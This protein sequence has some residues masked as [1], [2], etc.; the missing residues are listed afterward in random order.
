MS[1][2]VGAAARAAAYMRPADPAKRRLRADQL[3]MA[4]DNLKASTLSGIIVMICLSAASLLWMASPLVAVWLAFTIA[5]MAGA[6]WISARIGAVRDDADAVLRL[7]REFLGL[8]ALRSLA[9]AL[10]PIAMWVA[11]RPDNHV[12]LLVVLISGATINVVLIA[13]YKPAVAIV[14]VYCLGGIAVCL[15][16]GGVY[17]LASVLVALFGF[18]MKAIADN[19]YLVY[20]SML[21]LRQSER[22]LIDQ[23]HAANRTKAD[24][25]A[26]MSHEL[27]TPLNA[28]IGFSEVMKLELLGPIGTKAYAGY[29]NDIHASGSHLLTLINQ[30]LDLSKLEAGKYE[31]NES[32]FDLSGVVEEAR[33][34]IA[35]RAT[36]GGVTLR[37]E[38]PEGVVLRA[39]ITAIRQVAI[40]V[41]MN[42]IKFTMPGGQVR[43]TLRQLAD[44]RHCLVLSD[45][46]CGIRPED[47]ERVFEPFGQ[48][49]HDVAAKENGTGLGLPIVRSLMRAHGGDAFIQSE[50]GRGTK[51][52]LTL[53]AER[54]VQTPWPMAAAA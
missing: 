30:V 38:V 28:V 37:N 7:D 13:C 40:N 10:A 39:D 53:P 16:Q 6:S 49:R 47:I 9:V 34:I 42:A 15:W 45:T 33:R 21:E 32:E 3:V 19:I 18:M 43:A 24:F 8:I 23:L 2:A 20:L 35:L 5:A 51:V 50:L 48:G 46:G 54:L 52:F 22:A 1:I 27:R 25:L 17:A 11:D 29:A 31:L 26:N 36:E 12:L 14:I 44:G 4:A 41:A